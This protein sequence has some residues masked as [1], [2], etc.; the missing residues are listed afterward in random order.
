MSQ[1]YHFQVN[2]GSMLDVLSNHL[3]KSPGVFLRELLQNGVDAI[4]ARQRAQPSWNKGYIT[5]ELDECRRM[6]FR[7][8]GTGL[9]EEDIHCFLAVIGQSSKT[10]LVNGKI[11]ED[12][13]GRFGIGL[14]SCFMVS[15]TIVV[16]TKPFRGGQ[17]HVWTGMPDGTYTLEVLENCPEGTAILLNA[18]PGSEDYFTRERVEELV[19]YYGLALPVPIYLLGE[20]RPINT[21]PTDFWVGNR[22]QLLSFGGWLFGEEFLDAIP[23]H[24]IHLSGVAYILPYTTDVSVK[25]GHRIYLKQMLLTEH[26]ETLLPSWAFFLRCFLITNSLR[27]TASREDFYEDEHLELA[28][29]EFAQAIG[30]YLLKLSKEN[31]DLL[32]QITHVHQQA[33]K[34]MAIWDNDLFHLF[35]DYLRFETSEGVMTGA[36]LKRVNKGEWV[37]SVPKFQQLKPI[38]LSQGRLLICTGYTYDND[39]ISKLAQV[40]Q[41]SFAPL[42]E[43]SMDLVMEDP[44]FTE[45]QQASNL[46]RCTNR[47]LDEFDCQAQLRLF[48]PVD[49]PALYV[50]SDE[51]QF[52]RKIQS[53]QEESGGVF[54]DVLSSLLDSVEEKP[55]ATLYLNSNSPLVQWLMN[56]TD[57]TKLEYMAQVLYVQALLA[58]GY[59]LRRGEL[60]TM[61]NALLGLLSVDIE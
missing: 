47:V 21:I 61:N 25:T 13:I 22:S 6:V 4:T 53:V 33:I 32:Q 42:R 46:L 18:K 16:H 8:N 36:A 30:H 44:T 60:K 2:L 41:L 35:I 43:E 12:Y 49:L 50:M 20:E 39:L 24:T 48:L 45:K 59:P 37:S 40:Y 38:F 34:S 3:Y 1:S 58:G 52:L 15:D 28:R 57:H 9:S 23:I 31:P 11:L 17:G 14:L 56:L 55:L 19:L 10:E 5:I 29:T 54:S 51:V 27:P 7:D 26:G